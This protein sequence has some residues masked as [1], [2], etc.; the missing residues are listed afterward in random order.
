MRTLKTL[1][2]EFN[3]IT[4]FKLFEIQVLDTRTNENDYV[5]FDL[6]IS[7]TKPVS[8]YAT[9]EALTHKDEQSNLIAFQEIELD[10]C[11][12]L[13]EHLQEL[14]NICLVALQNSDFYEL[15]E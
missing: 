11:F 1:I 13:D 5:I 9:H 6:E 7:E 14:N 12:S 15:A 3:A 10:K 4:K 2:D 8:I